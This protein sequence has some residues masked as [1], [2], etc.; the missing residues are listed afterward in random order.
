MRLWLPPLPTVALANLLLVAA[1]ECDIDDLELA[2]CTD[3][4]HGELGEGFCEGDPVN[5]ETFLEQACCGTSSGEATIVLGIILGAVLLVR[6][7]ATPL[8]A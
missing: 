1:A 4:S 2:E 8:I 3:A 7:S 6:G 5:S